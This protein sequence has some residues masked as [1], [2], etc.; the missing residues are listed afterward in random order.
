MHLPVY[1]YKKK[2]KKCSKYAIKNKIKNII[3][4]QTLT[5]LAYQYELKNSMNTI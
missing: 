3:G 2:K 4:Y 5:E 1:M